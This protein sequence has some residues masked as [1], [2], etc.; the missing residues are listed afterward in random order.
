MPR[1]GLLWCKTLA[2]ISLPTPVSPCSSTV[3]TSLAARRLARSRTLHIDLDTAMQAPSA[4]IRAGAGA[5]MNG[6]RAAGGVL[7]DIVGLA[8]RRGGLCAASGLNISQSC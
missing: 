5:L 3:R 2:T 4:V 6:L 1:R 7:L 8:W